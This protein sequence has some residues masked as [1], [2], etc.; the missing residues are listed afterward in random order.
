VCLTLSVGVAEQ[1]SVKLTDKIKMQV[2]VEIFKAMPIVWYRRQIIIGSHA[3]YRI[4]PPA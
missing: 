1:G 3:E 4:L 2:E